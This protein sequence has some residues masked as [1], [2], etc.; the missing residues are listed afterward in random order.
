MLRIFIPV[1]VLFSSC[2]QKSDCS[3]FTPSSKNYQA[4][5]YML[6]FHTGQD[7]VGDFWFFP[8]CDSK[9]YDGSTN[10][11]KAIFES[12]FGKGIYFNMSLLGENA[13]EFNR[14]ATCLGMDSTSFLG[15]VWISKAKIAVTLPATSVFNDSPFKL[16]SINLDYENKSLILESYFIA[17]TESLQI[18]CESVYK[19]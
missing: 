5:G 6:N 3:D 14:S 17:E 8:S 1:I 12:N 16:S 19:K 4:V 7:G 18:E 9:V 11:Y 2:S 15:N 10:I 13:K